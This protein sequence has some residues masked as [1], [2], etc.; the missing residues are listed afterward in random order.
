M[1][2]KKLTSEAYSEELAALHEHIKATREVSEVLSAWKD[3]NGY[4]RWAMEKHYW[5]LVV[6]FPP[7]IAAAHEHGRPQGSGKY[8]WNAFGEETLEKVFGED[9]DRFATQLKALMDKTQSNYYSQ[10]DYYDDNYQHVLAYQRFQAFEASLI[11]H[12]VKQYKT[13]LADHGLS[14]AEVK[15][16]EAYLAKM[17]K[18][19]GSFRNPAPK[20][21]LFEAPKKGKYPT[22][23]DT[24]YTQYLG[25]VWSKYGKSLDSLKTY[26]LPLS[27]SDFERVTAPLEGFD[28]AEICATLGAQKRFP[29]EDGQGSNVR[30]YELI[31]ALPAAITTVFENKTLAGIEAEINTSTEYLKNAQ[32]GMRSF[33]FN[34]LRDLKMALSWLSRRFPGIE[35]EALEDAKAK[36]AAVYDPL[37]AVMSA[38]AVHEKHLGEIRFSSSPTLPPGDGDWPEAL[39]PAKEAI[40]GHVFLNEAISNLGTMY[41]VMMGEQRLQASKKVMSNPDSAYQVL[42]LFPDPSVGKDP[43]LVNTFGTALE[44]AVAN[45][46]LKIEFSPDMKLAAS[47]T[48]KLKMSKADAGKIK[49]RTQELAAAAEANVTKEAVLPENFTRPFKPYADP[50]LQYDNLVEAIEEAWSLNWQ[51]KKIKVKH[52]RV[53]YYKGKA[54]EWTEELNPFR[55]PVARLTDSYVGMVYEGDDGRTYVAPDG[56]QFRQFHQRGKGYGTA[57][58]VLFWGVKPFALPPEQVERIAR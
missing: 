7:L 1:A 21:S 44:A 13:A 6:E 11:A 53:N 2:N 45:G 15:K 47:G 3:Y 16:I 26:G 25:D 10:E 54:M 19:I 50:L 14:A 4:K 22:F 9:H 33:G 43:D 29:P 48:L 55:S 32:G 20:E 41:F 36:V 24:E 17:E 38:G 37:W 8:I 39:N 31:A 27:S 34:G 40:Y 12:G 56:I 23:D 5:D 52:L 49:A 18:E 30:T 57:L 28:Y 42:Q 35:S 51:G 58:N 46:E